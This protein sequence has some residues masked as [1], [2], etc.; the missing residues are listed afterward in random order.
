[1][2][3]KCKIKSLKTEVIATIDLPKLVGGNARQ[4]ER[5][6]KYLVSLRE[7]ELG[8]YYIGREAAAAIESRILSMH[9]KHSCASLKIAANK[10]A[11]RTSDEYRSLEL[12][13][14]TLTEN[15]KLQGAWLDQ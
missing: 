11:Y 7:H 13:Y 15:G 14:D 6:D 5:F 3:G 1:M 2:D 12:Q 9:E 4:T 8:H 10:L